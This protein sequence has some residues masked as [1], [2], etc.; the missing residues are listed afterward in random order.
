MEYEV[1][2]IKD[3]DSY[4]P[5]LF[6]VYDEDNDFLDNTDDFLGRCQI[7][8]ELCQAGGSLVLQSDFE[9]D[10]SKEI[11]MTPQWHK[12][13]FQEG[14]KPCGEVLCSFAVS[15]IDHN[16]ETTDAARVNLRSLV[17]KLDFDV[18]M[19]ILGLRSLQSPGILPVKKAFIEFLCSSLVPPSL[20]NIPN[21]KTQPGPAGSNPTINTTMK[22]DVPLPTDPL[23][24]P[25]LTCF[26]YDNISL[27]FS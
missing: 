9:K 24:C 4:P 16:F 18:N 26:V 1:R 5:F 19:L 23:Y 22:I 17:P 15:V 14:E 13:Y 6:D 2:D 7:E 27:G 12:F 11:P 20:H 21:V 3:P 25:R 10:K 8:P